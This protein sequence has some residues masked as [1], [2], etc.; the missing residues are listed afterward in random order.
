MLDCWE[1][2]SE[3]I[4]NE[5]SHKNV[6]VGGK[7]LF[8]KRNVL[9]NEGLAVAEGFCTDTS[10]WY[11]SEKTNWQKVMNTTLPYNNFAGRW[12]AIY[13]SWNLHQPRV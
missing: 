10:H 3:R 13:Y 12:S 4:D 7:N 2:T 11:S 5:P 6:H 8:T 9:Q 1:I